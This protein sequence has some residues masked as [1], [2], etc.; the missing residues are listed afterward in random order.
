MSGG[1]LWL[2]GSVLL[3]LTPAGHALILWVFTSA[4][5]GAE[6]RSHVWGL[7]WISVS[8][9]LPTAIQLAS[10]GC[11]MVGPGMYHMVP[12]ACGAAA[13]HNLGAVHAH[14]DCAGHE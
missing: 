12:H 5:G 14:V 9:V 10:G 6:L 8:L 1:P 11:F 2:L 7:S 4:E 3:F 13:L